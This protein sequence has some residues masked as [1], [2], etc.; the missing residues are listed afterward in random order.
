MFS[1]DGIK[2]T[3]YHIYN[4]IQIFPTEEIYHDYQY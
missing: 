3:A 2:I 4:A 1:I